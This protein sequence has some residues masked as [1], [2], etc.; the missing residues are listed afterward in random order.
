MAGLID[1]LKWMK[2]A[3]ARKEK[4][5]AELDLKLTPEIVRDMRQ[6][7]TNGE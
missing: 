7:Q 2:R 3:V 1:S 6:Q 4:R 5:L